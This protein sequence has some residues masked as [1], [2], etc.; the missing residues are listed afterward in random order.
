MRASE[1][2]AEL[3]DA[4]VVSRAKNAINGDKFTRLWSG[5][6]S[7]YPFEEQADAALCCFLAYWVGPDA[8]RIER[9]FNQSGLAKGR[10]WAKRPGYR[11]TTIKAAIAKV[12]EFEPI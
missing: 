6:T 2:T 3:D 12:D 11:Q 5:D 4:A 9:L 8:E 1:A 7:E 10:Q